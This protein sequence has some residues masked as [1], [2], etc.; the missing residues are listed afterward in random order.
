MGETYQA[1]S[2][3]S[4]LRDNEDGEKAKTGAQP[5]TANVP[6]QVR[7]RQRALKLAEITKPMT[8]EMNDFM[9]RSALQR[10]LKAERV[11]MLGG[12]ASI[13]QKLLATLA[14]LFSEDFK[15]RNVH[16]PFPL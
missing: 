12:V 14:T 16:Y 8:P 3:V 9:A 13:R 2:V 6:V 1:T 10:V 5:P 15:N 11:A 7:P 4:K